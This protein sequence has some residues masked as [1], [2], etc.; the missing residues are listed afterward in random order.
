MFF[1]TVF[2]KFNVLIKPDLVL[3]KTIWNGIFVFFFSACY[4]TTQTLLFLSRQQNS[5]F[6]ALVYLEYH[7][8]KAWL[9]CLYFLHTICMKT[10]VRKFGVTI[11][12]RIVVRAGETQLRRHVFFMRISPFVPPYLFRLDQSLLLIN[13][14]NINRLHAAICISLSRISL[15]L[16][17]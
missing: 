11:E 16:R 15:M 9:A 4:S 13:S 2:F 17:F 3:P 14:F 7:L 10:D 1:V 6:R 5:V 8:S 12:Y